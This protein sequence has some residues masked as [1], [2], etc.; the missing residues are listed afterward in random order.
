MSVTDPNC[1][2]CK[3]FPEAGG[4]TCVIEHQFP[5]ALKH[6]YALP[7]LGADTIP[8]YRGNFDHAGTRYRGVITVDL[9]PRPNL[10]A[11][12]VHEVSFHDGFQ[13][14]IGKREPA[15]WVDYD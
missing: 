4:G 12:G 8:V 6:Y 7:P 1:G 15:R 3:T 11:R 14:L 10:V 2:V 5:K 9:A 13:T